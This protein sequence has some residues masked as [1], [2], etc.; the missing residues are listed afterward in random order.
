LLYTDYDRV[1]ASIGCKGYKAENLAA[2]SQ[3]LAAAS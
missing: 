1:A 3:H 2:L